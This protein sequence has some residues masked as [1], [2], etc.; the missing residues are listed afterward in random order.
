MNNASL[1]TSQTSNPG[2]DIGTNRGTGRGHGV[3]R[4]CPCLRT[5]IVAQ[6][7]IT[8]KEETVSCWPLKKANGKTH[9][10]HR[11]MNTFARKKS[12]VS[13]VKQQELRGESSDFVWEIEQSEALLQISVLP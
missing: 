11:P 12:T 2:W 10:V 7:M 3:T 4:V 9:R 8:A 1:K 13:N 5:G 6:R